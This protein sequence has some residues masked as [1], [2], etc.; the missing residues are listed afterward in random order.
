M[1]RANVINILIDDMG[2]KDLSCY[3]SSFYETPVIDKLA[4]EGM[5]F[6]NAYAACPVCSPSRASML[7]GK[8]PARLGV[9]DWIGADTC[10]M[11]ASVPYL[12]HLP[13]GELTIAA[14]FRQN[15]YKTWHVGK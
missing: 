13:A 9:T 1:R 15:G 3:G 10:G 11:L 6:S 14:V 5:M 8:Y 12:H 4:R 2:W 7:T